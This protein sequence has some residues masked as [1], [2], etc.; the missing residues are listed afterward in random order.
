MAEEKDKITFVATLDSAQ[1]AAGFQQLG[2]QA[3][4]ALSQTARESREAVKGLQDVGKAAKVSADAIKTLAE[5][6]AAQGLQ[7]GAA[8]LEA[9]G[10]KQTAGYL[11]AVGGS[12]MPAAAAGFMA[13]G[14][15]G[16]VVAGIGGAGMG[17]AT[18]YFRQEGEEK[19]AAEARSRTAAAI[20]QSVKDF[21]ALH[22][23]ARESSEFFAKMGN[24]MLSAGARSK[25]LSDRIAEFEEKEKKLR[26][27]IEKLVEIENFPLAQKMTGRLQRT[28]AEIDKMRAL[29]IEEAPEP[30]DDSISMAQ[31]QRVE[32]AADSLSKLGIF[33]GLGGGINTETQAYQRDS[34]SYARQAVSLL[35]RI[36]STR[37][38]AV[39]A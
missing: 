31:R 7:L 35:S 9:S 38:S 36:S 32:P 13:F 14:V 24:T 1:A 39:F 21:D 10:H 18:E 23:A 37:E 28:V 27:G 15:P 33:A 34:L 30:E 16:A 20:R 26:A 17:A 12:A 2:A 4:A 25:E 19:Q 29:Q 22:A 5:T 11:S 8:A 6:F 3:N